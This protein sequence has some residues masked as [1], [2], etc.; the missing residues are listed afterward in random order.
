MATAPSFSTAVER[1]P[2][3][4]RPHRPW[5]AALLSFIFPGLGQAYARRPRSAAIF[6]IPV[7]L[8]ITV[9][10]VLMGLLGG[11]LRNA[12][13]SN[14]FLL[15]VL[16][17]NGLLFIWR[18]IAISDAGLSR[19]RVVQR[20]VVHR[21]ERRVAISAVA[22]LLLAT[23]AMHG[24]VAVV[25]AHLDDTLAQVF[26]ADQP[27]APAGDGALPGDDGEEPGVTPAPV[28]RWDGEERVNVL[29]VGTDAAPGRGEILTDVMLVVSID[30]VGRTAAMISIPRDTGYLPLQSDRIYVDGRFPGKA[31]ELAS[32]AATNPDLWCPNADLSPR[33]CG[34]RTLQEAI[35]LY[36]GLDLQHYAAV[37]MAG[38]AE[39]IDALGGIR[40]CL[41]GELVDPLFGDQLRPGEAGVPLVLAAGCH[42]YAGLEALAYARSR[43]GHIEMPDGRRIAQTDFDRNERQQSLLVAVRDELA[44]ADLIFELP[45]VLSAIGRTVD[46][47]FPRDQA[48]DLASLLPL[49]TGR[50]IERVV[51]DYPQFVDAPSEPE[52]NYLLEP[53]RDSIREEMERL[54]GADALRGWYLATE[55]L[56]P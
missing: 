27:D 30:P 23:L 47:D 22:L 36:V 39:L 51:L 49:I 13:L 25:V 18:A 38:F 35:G 37:D 40:L 8:L 1:H 3:T 17:L 55:R 50:D 20:R 11:V 26:T 2:L 52:V 7:V 14:S 29:L 28:Y 19:P 34:I 6:A 33:Q 43:Q 48:G 15:G 41:P 32:V 54:F 9:G 12:L 46:T 4:H 56:S 21:R 24:W 16:G 5:L 53:R 31:N 45:A 44:D 42:P 10:L